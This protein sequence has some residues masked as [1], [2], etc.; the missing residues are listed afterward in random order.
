M[1]DFLA[2]RTMSRLYVVPSRMILVMA[3]VFPVS[4]WDLTRSVS[5]G[6]LVLKSNNFR[7]GAEIATGDLNA[8]VGLKVEKS[9]TRQ[10]ESLKWTPFSKLS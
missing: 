2:D 9:N 8:H 5:A 6:S 7:H 4:R 3:T 1:W 10:L